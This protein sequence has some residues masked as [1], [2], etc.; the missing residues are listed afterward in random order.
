MSI[1]RWAYIPTKIT[2]GLPVSMYQT[3]SVCTSNGVFWQAFSQLLAAPH[4]I[5]LKWKVKSRQI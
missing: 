4:T 5:L 2:G 1:V 3:C